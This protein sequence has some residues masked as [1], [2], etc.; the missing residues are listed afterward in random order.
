VISFDEALALIA[1]AA[2]PLGTEPVPLGEAKGRVL[3][4]PVTA[5]VDSPPW[6]V[7]SM[8][9]YAVRDADLPGRLAV[10]GESRPGPSG[11]PQLRAGRCVRIFTGAPV[12]DGADRVVIQEEVRREG[13]SAIFGAA[14]AARYIRALG[15]DFRAGDRLLEPGRPIDARALVAIAAAGRDAV[16][17]HRRPAL[18]LFA[19]GDEL[20][21]P[22][23]ARERGAIPDSASPGVMA[24]AQD[25]GAECIGRWRLRDALPMPEFALSAARAADLVVVTGGASVGE[26]DFAKA[27]FDDQGL[28]LIFSTVAIRPGK[29]AWFGRAGGRLVLGLPGNPTSAMVTAR[30]FLAPLLAGLVGRDPA[31]ALAW[32]EGPLAAPLGP[33]GERETFVRAR[34]RDGAAEPLGNQESHAQHALAEADVLIRRRPGAPAAAAGEAAALLCF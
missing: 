15:S 2:R 33:C 13:D 12:P 5:L 21:E 28:E 19:T 8:D 7:S 25:W 18:A 27:M 31:A 10:G 32:F 1:G 4:G 6:D 23:A 30:L 16:E 29:P 22:G 34:W 14:G 3:A 24:L 17:V 11:P 9:G 20:V 26:W